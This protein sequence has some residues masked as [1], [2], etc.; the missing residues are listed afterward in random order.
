MSNEWLQ[1]MINIYGDRDEPP[2]Q[3]QFDGADPLVSRL[4]RLLWRVY[5]NS[6][7]WTPSHAAMLHEIERLEEDLDDLLE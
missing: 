3:I 1:E 4:H 5:G 7:N 6:S 2:T